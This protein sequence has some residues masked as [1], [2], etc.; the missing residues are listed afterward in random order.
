MGRPK[1]RGDLK[2]LNLNIQANISDKLNYFTENT[3]ITK[4]YMVERALSEYFDKHGNELDAL[5]MKEEH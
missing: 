2:P 1:T 4:T 3:G 5:T